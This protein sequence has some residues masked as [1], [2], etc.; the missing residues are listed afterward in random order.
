M[1]DQCM[2]HISTLS[3]VGTGELIVPLFMHF[4]NPI[5]ASRPQTSVALPLRV[6]W[7]EMG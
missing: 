4:L 2:C 7:G 6:L 5:I 1:P 3:P